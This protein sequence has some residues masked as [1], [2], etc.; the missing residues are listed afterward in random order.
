MD[1][2]WSLVNK[3]VPPDRPGCFN[4]SLMEL[5]ATI[6]TPKKPQCDK[7]PLA[8]MCSALKEKQGK[9]MPLRDIENC[10]TVGS[11]LFLYTYLLFIFCMLSVFFCMFVDFELYSFFYGL[12][13]KSCKNCTVH[14][15]NISQ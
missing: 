14:R 5:G 6:C 10:P 8:D 2:F 13:S 15:F 11:E 3:F 1:T 9:Q 4:Q 12:N 7:C